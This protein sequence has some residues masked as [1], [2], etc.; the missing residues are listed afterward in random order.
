MFRVALVGHSLLPTNVNFSNLHNVTVEVYRF[1]GATIDR[2]THELTE[3]DFWTKRYDGVILCIGGNDLAIQTVTSVFDKFC[4]LARR[5]KEVTRFLSICT[6]EYRLY[7]EGNRFGINQLEYKR[8]VVAI[9]HRIKRFTRSLNCR[10]LDMG[11]RCFTLRRTSD[12]V[13]FTP[14]GRQTFVYQLE[15]VVR[16]FTHQ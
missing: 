6:I 1:P 14:H 5:V 3:I 15:R 13:H 11:K 16:A 8:K 7:P 10:N 9:N 4:I 12:G 2:L